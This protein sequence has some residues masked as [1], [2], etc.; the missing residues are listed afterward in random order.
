MQLWTESLPDPWP[1]LLRSLLCCQER[2]PQ[3]SSGEFHFI[4]MSLT[5]HDHPTEAWPSQGHSKSLHSSNQDHR[6]TFL[7]Q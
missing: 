1:S 6:R 4:K 3:D 2:C 5:Q 7:L